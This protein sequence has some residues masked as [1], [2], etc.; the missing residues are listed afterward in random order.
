MKFSKMKV[1]ANATR[2]SMRRAARPTTD[3]VP[4]PATTGNSSNRTASE[5]RGPSSLS[6]DEGGGAGRLVMCDDACGGGYYPTAPEP[7]GIRPPC[8]PPDLA[9]TVAEPAEADV[10]ILL[11]HGIKATR[12][13]GA[14]AASTSG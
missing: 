3:W 12:T 1:F 5:V 11:Q 10:N 4:L 7:L 14:R 2:D 13:P 8:G 6:T 9:A